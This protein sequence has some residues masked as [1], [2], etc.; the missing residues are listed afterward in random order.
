M[1]KQGLQNGD[2]VF[3]ANCHLSISWMPSLEQL[4]ENYC[5]GKDGIVPHKEF[6]LWLSCKPH[7][8][9]PIT[10]LQR[11]LKITTEPPTGV[12][13]NMYRLYQN[14]TEEQFSLC[15]KPNEYRKLL[16]SLVWFHSLLLERR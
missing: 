12:K 16:F 1:L 10:I 9:F 2:W 3:F 5:V 14:I 6:R 15:N 8:K 13:N 4:I 11:A 7:P